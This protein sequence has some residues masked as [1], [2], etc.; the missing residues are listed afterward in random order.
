MPPRGHAKTLGLEPS[1]PRSSARNPTRN[2]AKCMR[3]PAST[4]SLRILMTPPRPSSRYKTLWIS[5]LTPRRGLGPKRFGERG[6]GFKGRPRPGRE[7]GCVGGRHQG[8][9][10]L[11][12]G[13]AR[14]VIAFEEAA[15]K[16]NTRIGF[17]VIRSDNNQLEFVSV[18]YNAKPRKDQVPTESEK[19]HTLSVDQKLRKRN[20]N[21]FALR[22]Q[23]HTSSLSG[24]SKR[25]KSN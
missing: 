19:P 11:K 16:E 1:V 4:S 7:K 24:G 10:G 14:N 23:K 9:K 25:R 18:W 2:W 8:S 6:G 3:F 12:G 15:S 21:V 20:R 17:R 13:I 22:V 5:V